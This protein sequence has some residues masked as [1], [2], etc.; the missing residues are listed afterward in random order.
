[1]ICIAVQMTEQCVIYN[2]LK[3]FAT[4]PLKKYLYIAY[5]SF[6]MKNNDLGGEG[7]ETISRKV[8]RKVF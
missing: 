5:R 4:P 2:L 8:Q 7:E 1:M 3:D 6:L